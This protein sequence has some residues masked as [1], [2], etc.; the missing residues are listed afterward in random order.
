VKIDLLYL[1]L[2]RFDFNRLILFKFFI[3]AA[4]AS[5]CG[6]SNSKRSSPEPS[7]VGAPLSI[8]NPNFYDGHASLNALGDRAVFISGREAGKLRTY[9]IDLAAELSASSEFSPSLLH[10]LD[11]GQEYAAEISPNGQLVLFASFN[12]D[13]ET[14]YLAN[15]SRQGDPIKI[16]PEA[17]VL[18][19]FSFSPDSNLIAF[20]VQTKDK[21]EMLLNVL[22]VSDAGTVD[23]YKILTAEGFSEFQPK[24]INKR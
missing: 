14:L 11:F 20:S 5:A 10:D 8:A 19:G 2:K 21:A 3:I 6:S 12:A 17:G 18:G 13:G 7:R 23:S 16:T 4:L 24:W 9:K 1:R 22:Q 15:Y